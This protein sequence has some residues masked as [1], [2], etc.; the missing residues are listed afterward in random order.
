MNGVEG[1]AGNDGSGR[2]ETEAEHL[3]RNLAE[4]IQELRVA[5]TGVQILFAFLL[6]VAFTSRFERATTFQRWTYF[7]TL[8]CAAAAS[9]LLIAPAARHRMLFRLHDRANLIAASN[10]LA[11]AGLGFLAAAGTG[12]MLLITDVLFGTAPAVVTATGVAVGYFTLWYLLPMI[13]RLQR[14]RE[15]KP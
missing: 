5:V 2:D 10:R 15:L 3:D 14:L 4:L 6:T 11:L 13:R 1:P 8:L 7:V 12:A 9:A